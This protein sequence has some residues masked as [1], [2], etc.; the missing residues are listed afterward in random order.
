M[1]T[2]RILGQFDRWFVPDIPFARLVLYSL[3]LSCAALLVFLLAYV[4]LT[5]GFW[6]SVVQD[7]VARRHLL[8]QVLTNGLP[9]VFIINHIGFSL[10][11]GIAAG[12]RDRGG[13]LR[14]LAIDA[15][16]RIA[17]FI[18]AHAA[19]YAASARMFGSFG[20][21]T[22]QALEVVGPTLAQSAFFN[23]LSG[24]YLYA[25]AISA[26]PL[27]LAAQRK[28]LKDHPNQVLGRRLDGNS[29]VVATAAFLPAFILLALTLSGLAA[30]LPR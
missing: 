30:L 20:G 27:F 16:A 29:L 11:A 21:D 26:Y 2:D 17:V 25:T 12:P 4:A 19:I 13:A 1:S 7:D 14:A 3:L 10:Y 9:I 28:F 15:P 22:R 18:L 24:V 6:Q 5:P 8:R 23:N